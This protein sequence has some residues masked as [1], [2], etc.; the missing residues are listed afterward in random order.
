MEDGKN[1]IIHGWVPESQFAERFH[2]PYFVAEL[3]I[4]E[5]EIIKVPIAEKK[6]NAMGAA[7]AAD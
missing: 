7:D 2:V 4:P 1:D 5:I 3:D 6:K